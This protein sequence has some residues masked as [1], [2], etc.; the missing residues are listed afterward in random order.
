MRPPITVLAAACALFVT[1]TLGPA[2]ERWL[3]DTLIRDEAGM[4]R[5]VIDARETGTELF[6]YMSGNQV[7]EREA[8]CRS[9]DSGLTWQ[10]VNGGWWGTADHA[11]GAAYGFNT[12]LRMWETNGLMYRTALNATTGT[13]LHDGFFINESPRHA[14]EIVIDSNAES[15]PP[16]TE[17]FI[18]CV[19]FLDLN[20]NQ[21][22]L[23]SYRS[24]DHGDT[25]GSFNVLDSGPVGD[26][27]Y[28]GDVH[29]VFSVAG[30]PYFHVCY[31]KGGRIWSA[32]TQ[33]AGVSWESPIE[34]IVNVADDSQVSVAAF[35]VYAIAAGAS[36]SNQVVYCRTTDAGASW[37]NAT[38][39]DGAQPI[40][41]MPYV[42]YSGGRWF[43][44]YR[45]PD[46]RLAARST[47]TPE[48]PL[49]WSAEEY[50]TFGTTERPPWA[51]AF[52]GSNIGLVYARLD[53]NGH[54]YFA[55][56]NGVPSALDD[57]PS[58]GVAR[59]VQVFPVPSSGQVTL[60][61]QSPGLRGAGRGRE[62]GSGKPAGDRLGGAVVDATGR[63]IAPLGPWHLSAIEQEISWDGRDAGGHAV[64][65]GVYYL[66]V[67][68]PLGL[69]TGRALIVR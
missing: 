58:S 46:Q 22:T 1:P 7:G 21:I 29:M 5:L 23:K 67:W 63:W 69:R 8:W 68:T 15:G 40:A 33:N 20:T 62:L 3:D 27:D 59:E 47:T 16:G 32:R 64:P 2:G 66:R 41:R 56:R 10:F 30:Y 49:S 34:L 4:D 9:T 24:T 52:G 45:Q 11:I 31:V 26:P 54:P 57:G 6:A 43:G 51:V 13:V 12:L 28:I 53:D 35:G 61:L 38:L 42:A 25:W 14:E 39:M 48:E 19:K 18:A 17:I 60:L 55:S 65:A 37:S 50:A 36:P 44:I